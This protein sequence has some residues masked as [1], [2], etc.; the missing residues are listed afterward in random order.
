MCKN[1]IK[2]QTACGTSS[3]LFIDHV[4]ANTNSKMNSKVFKANSAHIQLNG[5]TLIGQ[6]F[7]V[8]MENDPKHTVKATQRLFDGKEI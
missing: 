6:C 5:T 7:I 1:I 4:I 3:L 8:Q 2:S